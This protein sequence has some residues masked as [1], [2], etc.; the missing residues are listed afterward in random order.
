[1]ENAE[2]SLSFLT[3][4]QMTWRGE[5]VGGEKR[6]G[7]RRGGGRRGGRSRGERKRALKHERKTILYILPTV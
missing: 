5:E 2:T 1:M 7:R 3:I 6:G 4:I